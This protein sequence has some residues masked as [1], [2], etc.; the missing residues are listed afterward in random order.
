MNEHN[1]LYPGF[2]PIPIVTPQQQ[3][4][5]NIQVNTNSYYYQQ[6][7]I[8]QQYSK[9]GINNN[10]STQ[11][12]PI[13]Q[14]VFTKQTN[15]TSIPNNGGNVQQQ[16]P[17]INS[18]IVDAYL[19]KLYEKFQNF[20]SHHLGVDGCNFDKYPL[21]DAK[22]CKNIEIKL[23]YQQHLHTAM[24][25]FMLSSEVYQP[26]KEF[27]QVDVVQ[28]YIDGIASLLVLKSLNSDV[29]GSKYSKTIAK[30]TPVFVAKCIYLIDKL[31]K[32]FQEKQQPQQ[33]QPTPSKT[34]FSNPIINHFKKEI[35]NIKSL[36]DYVNGQT[37][38]QA[39]YYFS[40]I[41]F[42]LLTSK[43]YF[44]TVD[45][46]NE[47]A[48]IPQFEPIRTNLYY[49]S[50]VVKDSVYKY[51]FGCYCFSFF[52]IYQQANHIDSTRFFNFKTSKSFDEKIYNTLYMF[53]KQSN[54]L[55][56]EAF[57]QPIPLSVIWLQYAKSCCLLDYE[58]K[59]HT[60]IQYFINEATD[61]IKAF[62]VINSSS[63]ISHYHQ[64]S[65]YLEIKKSIQDEKNEQLDK[66]IGL[67]AGFDQYLEVKQNLILEG[68]AV[69]NMNQDSLLISSN[70]LLN[71]HPPPQS[72][73]VKLAEKRLSE[74][75]ELYMLKNKKEI[76]GDGNCQFHA[77]SDQLYGDLSHSADIRKSIVQWLRKNK[78]H[79][80]TNGAVLSQFV[81]D[82]D[83]EQYCNE[84]EKLGTWGDH[85]TLLAA[86]E[87]YGLKIS[88]I[89]SVES[90]SHFFIE[91]IPTK[92]QKDK[93]LLLSHYAEFHYGSLCF[94]F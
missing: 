8:Q 47:F 71:L 28:Y 18:Q 31:C 9:Q 93:V 35:E 67:F 33:Q 39:L 34:T 30:L 14:Q 54:D 74:R 63:D 19:S 45:E 13:Q 50:T 87:I 80:L 53:L 2:Q 94:N 75:L 32:L 21:P 29:E 56:L 17:Q 40:K 81:G 10:N 66:D 36:I 51:S 65:W 91:V 42:S 92:I 64:K 4:Q 86:A 38:N 48:K 90:T 5:Q 22:Q 43:G 83:W 69:K 57:N 60:W 20:S 59:A 76:P 12:P 55:L 15:T 58:E 41:L 79:S 62:E 72:E 61:R 25:P 77:L 11:S 89:S 68:F 85:L 78:D 6:L 7:Q 16:T 23:Q 46:H 27:T 88:I 44:W 26:P 37:T 52:K 84:M 82:R 3:Q 70:I 73:T 49:L 24:L 1:I